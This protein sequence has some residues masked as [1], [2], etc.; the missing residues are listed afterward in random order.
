M[1]PSYNNRVGS[2]VQAPMQQPQSQPV[3]MSQSQPTLMP[4]SQPAPMSQSISQSQPASM[5][6]PMS[7]QQPMIA[8]GA[9]DVV[10]SGAGIPNKKPRRGLIIALIVLGILLVI[11]GGGVLLWQNGAFNRMFGGT[12]MVVGNLEEAYNSYTNYVLWG[13]E[14]V[15]RPS[16]EAIEEAQPYFESLGDEEKVAYVEKADAKYDRLRE[17]TEEYEGGLNANI[18][19]LKAFFEDYVKINLTDGD[20]V[21]AYMSDGQEGAQKIITDYYKVDEAK[22]YYLQG[23]LAAERSLAMTI[24]DLTAKADAAGCL[25]NGEIVEGCYTMTGEE[26]QKFSGDVLLVEEKRV[27]LRRRAMEVLEIV[28]GNLYG[29]EVGV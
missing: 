19:T 25:K 7:V 8:S 29:S 18:G 22:D 26:S 27:A 4:Q 16:L 1:N 14:S 21:A 3:P 20:I 28:Y 11:A 2:Q 5:P 9:G 13:T 23:V 10:L 17:K 24:L 15:E 6:Q 12:Q